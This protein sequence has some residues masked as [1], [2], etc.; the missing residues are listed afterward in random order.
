MY[1]AERGGGRPRRGKNGGR[2]DGRRETG[3][4]RMQS[5]L[6]LSGQKKESA[7]QEKSTEEDEQ[8]KGRQTGR[9]GW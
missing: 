4:E 1:A 3:L 5:G 2:G 9:P 7:V 6:Q 8:G